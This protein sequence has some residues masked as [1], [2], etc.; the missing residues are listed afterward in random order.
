MTRT[1]QDCLNETLVQAAREGNQ[2]SVKA[3]IALGANIHWQ[4]ELPLRQAAL[5]GHHDVFKELY[6]SGASVG[7]AILAAAS[8]GQVEETATLINLAPQTTVVCT[9]RQAI[10]SCPPR[11]NASPGAR[12]HNPCN[13]K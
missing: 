7:T 3:M 10:S 12:P 4:N 1:L 8:A 2:A 13:P 11:P 9:L 6:D 5:H